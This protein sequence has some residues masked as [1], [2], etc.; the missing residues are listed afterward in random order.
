MH[1]IEDEIVGSG[2]GVAEFGRDA[3]GN[4]DENGEKCSDHVEGCCGSP[5]RDAFGKNFD[6]SLANKERI[7]IET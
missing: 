4:G 7:L 1:E 5:S 2:K 6:H 3:S